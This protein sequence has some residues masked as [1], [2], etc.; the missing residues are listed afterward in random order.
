[1]ALA[2]IFHGVPQRLSAQ[3][4]TRT[5]WHGVFT[6]VQAD[7]GR[8]LFVE[9][10]AGCHGEN[11]EGAS[12]VALSGPRFIADW[13]EDSL[14]SLFNS[15]RRNMPRGRAG[16]LTD[17]SYADIVA[18]ILARNGFPAG[19]EQLQGETVSSIRV[20]GPDGPAAVPNFSLI[21]VVGCLVQA[22][23]QQWHLIAASEP[24]RTRNPQASSGPELSK[25]KDI[26]P[27]PHTFSLMDVYPGPS[28][29]SQQPV[30]VKGFLIR[31]PD[32]DRV[33]VTSIAPLDG[34]CRR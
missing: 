16:S 2:G 22:S 9:N 12:A 7:R 10:C 6:T 28:L 21:S 4:Q 24:V 30:E 18:Y 1:L 15:I 23:P 34:S 26:A 19:S 11:L 17:A 20:E 14:G 5:V 32:Q 27:G 33:N 3:A 29:H 25:L 13:S 31:M 8:Q